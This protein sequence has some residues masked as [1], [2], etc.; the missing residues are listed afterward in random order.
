MEKNRPFQWPVQALD[1]AGSGVTGIAANITATLYSD[2][3]TAGTATTDT[4]PIEIGSE[5]RYFFAI[6]SSE[7]NVTEQLI[8]DPT[9]TAATHVIPCPMM[10]SIS[11]PNYS[12]LGIESDGDVTKVNTCDTNTDMVSEPM[13]SAA[14]AT[15]IAAELAT[16]DGPTKAEMDSAFTEIKGA[17]WASG[18]DTLEHIRNKQTDIETDT[19][20]IETKV[21]TVDGNVDAILVDTNALNDTK[22]PDTLSLANINAEVDT[23]LN[24][25]IPGSPTAGSINEYVRDTKY[26][27]VNKLTV[28]ESTG[29]A[30]VHDDSD[31]SFSTSGSFTTLAGVAT[32]E[33][34]T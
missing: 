29:A 2:N 11:P 26:V 17:T 28:N 1:S 31:V 32:R 16:Y 14:T 10:V 19:Q 9:T 23:A 8:L 33:K 21:D 25:A 20:S 6:T 7:T 34:L 3:S 15:T 24:T 27:T 30:T 4:N 12:E 22:V 13:A 5:G 18:T